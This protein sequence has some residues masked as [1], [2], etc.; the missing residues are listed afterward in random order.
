MVK[1]SNKYEKRGCNKRQVKCIY[2][3]RNSKKIQQSLQRK[4]YKQVWF[5]RK[6]NKS[7]FKGI[8]EITLK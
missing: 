8:I 7:F 2:K 3:Q 5:D 1:T 6:P 4:F